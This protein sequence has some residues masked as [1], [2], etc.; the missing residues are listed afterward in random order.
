MLLLQ[1][2]QLLRAKARQ[3]R[4]ES[5]CGEC[6][7]WYIL[8]LTEPPTCCWYMTDER[9]WNYCC[10][11]ISYNFLH[12]L[13][14]FK[15]QIFQNFLNTQ[16]TSWQ[17]AICIPSISVTILPSTALIFSSFSLCR[18]SCRSLSSSRL[19]SASRTCLSSS[20]SFF[21]SSS[22]IPA[23]RLSWMHTPTKSISLLFSHA[24]KARCIE[25]YTFL[26]IKDRSNQALNQHIQQRE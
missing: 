18:S 6:P 13:K 22:S 7:L 20:S 17:C 1:I 9:M 12:I 26:Y 2:F 16:T 5:L 3:W 24:R 14:F 25:N 8:P 11:L 21:F 15:R 19:C 10:F 23:L 4:C